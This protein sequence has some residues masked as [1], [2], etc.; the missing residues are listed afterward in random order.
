MNFHI[1]LMGREHLGGVHGIESDCFSMPWGYQAFEEELANPL[2]IY[3]VVVVDGEVAGYAGM[4]H[5]I[6]E[7][8]ITNI[9]V[10]EKFRRHGFG[11]ALVNK[12]I[13]IAQTKDMTGLTLEVRM[14]NAAAM[15]LYAKRGLMPYGIRKNYYVDTKEDA[16]IMWKRFKSEVAQD[17]KA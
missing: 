9:A 1:E 16:V 3:V 4:H 10:A 5:I 13:E 12:L 11:D 6:D 17:E 7:G 15:R 2:A 8:H 14:G